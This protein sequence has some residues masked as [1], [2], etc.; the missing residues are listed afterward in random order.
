MSLVP[1]RFCTLA[2][3][4]IHFCAIHNNCEGERHKIGNAA[5]TIKNG[6]SQHEKA[7]SGKG[8]S[9]GEREKKEEEALLRYQ[10]VY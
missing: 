2:S 6:K 3:S 1:R 9:A 5:R 4:G 7:R 8:F 10:M